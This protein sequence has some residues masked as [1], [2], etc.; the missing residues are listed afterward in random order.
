[1]LTTKFN[2]DEMNADG[3][4]MT[5]KERMGIDGYAIGALK[6]GINQ[7]WNKIIY[8]FLKKKGGTL[9][10]ISLQYNTSM[11]GMKIDIIKYITKQ[12]SDFYKNMKENTAQYIAD[13]LIDNIKHPGFSRE[14][15]EALTYFVTS[16][17]V[18]RD[19]AIA[20]KQMEDLLLN[21]ANQLNNNGI[22]I[23]LSDKQYKITGISSRFRK[24][25]QNMYVVATDELKNNGTKSIGFYRNSN[26]LI[27]DEDMG[28]GATLKLTLDGLKNFKNN[29]NASNTMCLVNA[30]SFVGK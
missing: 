6:R 13:Y 10:K 5:D 3:V 18:I 2:E 28:S 9:Y 30:F 27:F 15:K 17:L 14:N 12:I 19:L 21:Y 25:L 29:M 11:E 1:L 7:E 16:K 23:T 24:Y 22:S 20:I 4:T 26:I 8:A